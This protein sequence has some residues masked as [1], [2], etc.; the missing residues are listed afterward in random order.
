MARVTIDDSAFI[1]A[2]LVARKTDWTEAEALGR[3]CLLWRDSQALERTEA[4]IEDIAFWMQLGPGDDETL[5]SIL[6]DAGFISPLDDGENFIIVG[7]KK[8]IDNIHNAKENAR[9][10]G[11]LGGRPKKPASKP[12]PVKK[13]NQSENHSTVQYSTE[14]YSTEQYSTVQTV[15][16]EKEGSTSISVDTHPQPE[17][18]VSLWNNYCGDLPKVRDLTPKR[19]AAIKARLR[20]K[21]DPAYWQE[22]ISR[23]AKSDFCNGAKGWKAGFDFLLRPDTHVKAMEGVY[24]NPAAKTKAQQVSDYNAQMHEKILRGE[25]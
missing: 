5:A 10:N 18:F 7:N 24:D 21:P 25:V 23:I 12:A 6:I 9:K 11:H 16:K 8:H 4:T 1:G 22:V 15:Q 13:N 17:V 14:Q 3:L 20:E 2:K 19:K